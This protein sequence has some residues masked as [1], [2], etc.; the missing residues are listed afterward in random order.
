MELA[1]I[2][3]VVWTI[4]VILFIFSKNLGTCFIISYYP[5][6]VPFVL[7]RSAANDY[8][9]RRACIDILATTY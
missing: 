7:A 9:G 2:F 6:D 5:Y 3:G 1:A 4:F 8:E